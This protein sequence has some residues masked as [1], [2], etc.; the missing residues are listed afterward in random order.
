MTQPYTII[1]LIKRRIDKRIAPIIGN[2][3]GLTG[4]AP[5]FLV[6]QSPSR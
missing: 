3:R 6:K 4:L 2:N 1:Q 5:T